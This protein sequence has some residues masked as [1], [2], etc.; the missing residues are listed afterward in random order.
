[1][2][3]VAFSGKSQAGKTT[4]A[5]HCVNVFGGTKIALA[6]AVKEEVAEFLAQ[7]GVPFEHR[8]LYGA[9][10]DKEEWCNIGPSK[11]IDHAP[12]DLYTLLIMFIAADGKGCTISLT[13]RQL[14]QIWGTEYRRAQDPAYWTRRC[15]EKILLT[16]GL[17]FIDDVRFPDEVEMVKDLGG[18]VIRIDRYKALGITTSDHPSETALDDYK[19]FD[20][21]ILNGGDVTDLKENVEEVVRWEFD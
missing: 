4:A 1:M 5:L 8:N 21:T 15:R 17:V 11:L 19:E 12:D 6:D 2:R 18:V 10:R 13:Y 9:M 14:L 20:H 16:E 7:C 3:I